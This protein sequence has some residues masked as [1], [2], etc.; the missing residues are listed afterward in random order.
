MASLKEMRNN[1]LYNNGVIL[2]GNNKL[3]DYDNPETGEKVRYAQFN[4]L[5]LTCCPFAT[6]G[7]KAVCY[8]TKGN[9]IYPSVKRSRERSYMESRRADFAESMVYTI[10]AEK[11][12]ARYRNAVMLMRIHESGDFYSVQYLRKWVNVWKE[13]KAGDGVRFVFYTKSFPFFL[14]LTEEEKAVV[15]NALQAGI[16]S[17][18]MS[19]DDTTSPEQW[20]AYF[21]MRKAFTLANTYR[22]TEST[23]GMKAD[24]VC[25][26]SDCAKCGKCNK[27]SGRET[28]VKIH[29]ASKA[30]MEVYRNNSK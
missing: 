29:S 21:E 8:A 18:N 6:E 22:C 23:E 9:H 3:L 28:F 27:A 30:D 12:S 2:S 1:S 20:K 11:Q 10:N 19:V 4:T 24:N 17:M 5:A 15:N 13:Y 26:C 16:V 7:C 25:D 14:M